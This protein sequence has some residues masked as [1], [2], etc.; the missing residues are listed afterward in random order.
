MLAMPM[1]ACKLLTSRLGIGRKVSSS[2]SPK[3]RALACQT[4]DAKVEPKK[5]ASV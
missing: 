1:H 2:V 3:Y 5:Q 4:A